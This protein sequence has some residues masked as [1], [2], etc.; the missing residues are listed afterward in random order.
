[1]IIAKKRE[2]RDRKKKFEINFQ[3]VDDDGE[4]NH[5]FPR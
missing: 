3:A 2:E 5:F 4:F 1:M